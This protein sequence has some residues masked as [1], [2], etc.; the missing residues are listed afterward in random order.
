MVKER[1]IIGEG[2]Y[3]CV[4]KPSLHCLHKNTNTK[5]K[6]NYSRYLHITFYANSTQIKEARGL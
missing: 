1:K 2:A 6:I 3:G 4:H 5:Q